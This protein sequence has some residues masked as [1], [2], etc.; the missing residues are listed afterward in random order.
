MGYF[1]RLKKWFHIFL[2]FS[3]AVFF[4]ALMFKN[5]HFN[6]VEKAL[7]ESNSVWVL[8]SVVVFLIGYGCRIERWRIMLKQENPA[9]QWT[10]CAGPLMASVAA[11]NLLPLRAGDLIRAFAFNKKMGITPSTSITTLVVE[12][13]LDLL[14][15]SIFLA[16]GLSVFSEQLHHA[17]NIG[18]GLVLA[19]SALILFLLLFPSFFKPVMVWLGKK[20]THLHS[21]YGNVFVS[22]CEKIFTSLEYISNRQTMTAL[23]LWSFFAWIA[24]GCVFWCI[25]CA[26]PSITHTYAAFL[27]LPL[28]TLATVIPSTPGYVG[29]FD[30]FTAQSMQW[31]GNSTASSTAFAFLL[32]MVLWFPACIAG[33][34]YMVLQR[35]ISVPIDTKD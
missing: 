28:G 8:V 3:T 12:R 13:L 4:L 35:F 29:T 10:Q 7:L 26:L 9:L 33:G 15:V 25:A 34:V 18:A 24:E 5:I 17:L 19:G 27:A 6:A 2:G 20:L 23:I 1:S 14:M 11:N 21:F 32:H 22:Q 16:L 31:L 30:Y